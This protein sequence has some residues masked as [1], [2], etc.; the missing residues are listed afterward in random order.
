MAAAPKL[1]AAGQARAQR[2]IDRIEA[3]TTGSAI[4][5]IGALRAMVR[6]TGDHAAPRVRR[7]PEYLGKK[8]DS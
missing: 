1:L 5:E 3:Q 4:L 8:V 2:L 7:T 6:Q